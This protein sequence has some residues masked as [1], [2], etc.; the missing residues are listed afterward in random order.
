MSTRLRALRP[1][2]RRRVLVI[3]GDDSVATA[4]ARL[5]RTAGIEVVHARDGERGLAV[6]IEEAPDVILLDL[7]LAKRDGIDVLPDL[8][9]EPALAS[10]PI[11]VV[12]GRSSRAAQ[13]AAFRAGR[14]LPAARARA[15]RAVRGQRAAAGPVRHR[16][17]DRTRQPPRALLAAGGGVRAGRAV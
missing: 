6:A 4:V 12:S 9:A 16:R 2:V 8:R 13:A 3:D 11:V 10:V 1:D 15:P 5:A 7:A 17:T 14:T